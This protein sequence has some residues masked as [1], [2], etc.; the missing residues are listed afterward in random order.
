VKPTA[1]QR[2]YEL[3]WLRVGLV[4]GA[5][6]YH[7]IYDAQAY[8]PDARVYVFTQVVP[9]FAVQCGLPLLFLVAGASAWLSLIHQ[10]EQQ[11]I[12]ERVQRL[13]VPFLCCLLTIIPLTDYFAA[14][15]SPSTHLSFSQYYVD[16]FRS[17]S[18]FLHEDPLDHITA[19]FRILWFILAIFVFS[20]VTSPLIAG[21]QGPHGERVIARFATVCQIPGGI[22][23]FALLFVLCYGLLGITVPAAATASPWLA[24]LY[25]L[26]FTGGIFLYTDPST[27]RAVYRDAPVALLLGTLGFA[28]VQILVAAQALP[29][30]HTAGFACTALLEGSFPWLGAIGLL[31][32]GKR[33]LTCT[34][35]SLVYLKEAVFPYFLL[36]MVFL[37][38][39]AYIFFVHTDWPGAV[40]AMAIIA[41]TV[42]SVLLVYE[43]VIK[44]SALLR[45][46]FGMKPRVESP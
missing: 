17:Y 26:S 2:R 33:F 8:F 22:L 16:Y 21:L 32:L 39:F 46:I 9:T 38:F 31:G 7:V 6:V 15:I 44:R 25:A 14:L 13:L 10:T 45:F 34:N 19:I 23:L 29:P 18:Q 24:A 43:Y 11:F 1:V 20:I 27:E 37:N 42:A 3:D 36:H 35:A 5:M 4:I 41:C 28:S 30:P 40:Q 12:R